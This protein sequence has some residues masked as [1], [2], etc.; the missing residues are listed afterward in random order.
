MRAWPGRSQTIP[1]DDGVQLHNILISTLMEDVLVRDRAAGFTSRNGTVHLGNV[2]GDPLIN[3]GTALHRFSYAQHTVKLS[4]ACCDKI[5]N[6]VISSRRDLSSR[7][8]QRAFA[9]F[10]KAASFPREAFAFITFICH[11]PKHMKSYFSRRGL[12]ASAAV[13][14]SI[15]YVFWFF[16]YD[17]NN[18]LIPHINSKN[19]TKQSGARQRKPQLLWQL[20]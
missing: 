1:V 19:G 20:Q 18:A 11:F 17:Y 8:D 14:V 16:L 3:H 13:T 9:R 5:Q 10:I 2:P 7:R 12:W 15:E 6:G 4:N